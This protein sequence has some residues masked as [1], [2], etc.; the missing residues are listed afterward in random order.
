MSF[1]WTSFATGFMEK[2]DE[3]WTNRRE[4]AEDYEEEQRKAAERNVAT[5]S[6]RRQIADQVT[7]YAA[8][9]KQNGVSDEQIQA[10]V[11]SG[12]EGISKAMARITEAVEANKGRPLGPAD[13]DTILN[14]PENFTPVDMDTDA[15]IRN[16]YGLGTP[17]RAEQQEESSFFDRLTGRSAMADARRR[18]SSDAMADGMSVQ[19]I[20]DAARNADYQT[21]IPGTFVTY[22]GLEVFNPAKDADAFIRSVNLQ[23]K[24]AQ[25]TPEYASIA[26][27]IENVKFDTSLSDAERTAELARLRREQQ[28]VL[29]NVVGPTIDSYMDTYGESFTDPMGSYVSSIMGADYLDGPMAVEPT[30]GAPIVDDLTMAVPPAVETPAVATD[31]LEPGM[32][33]TP[34]MLPL[35][36]P[37]VEGGE[38]TQ[39]MIDYMQGNRESTA[40]TVEVAPVVAPEPSSVVV[41]DGAQTEPPA[42]TAVRNAEGDVVTFKDWQEMSRSEREALDLPTSVIGGNMFFNRFLVGAGLADYDTGE[43]I[44]VS[45]AFSNWFRVDTPDGKSRAEREVPPA[46]EQDPVYKEMSDQ[47]VDDMSIALLKS[48]GGDMLSYLRAQGVTTEEEMAVKLSEW[49]Q[50]KGKTMPFSKMALIHALKPH[51]LK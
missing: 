37:D 10:I 21:L 42:D 22:S 16:T 40:A 12:P 27:A 11:S 25:E 38:L 50:A 30:Q 13:V 8:S 3:I 2:T 36:P 26:Q 17:T 39:D 7:G 46:V 34:E 18:L 48:D 1:D 47:G 45:E 5:I 19:E 28:D 33:I 43:R 14:L 9:L 23:V 32:R 31:T 24:A 29:R 20:N 44:P 41:P 15:F 51:V 4:K 49:G 6:R 35:L